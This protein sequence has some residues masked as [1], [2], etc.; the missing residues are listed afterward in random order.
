M[1]YQAVRYWKCAYDGVDTATSI[2]G[3][4]PE[5]WVAVTSGGVLNYFHN[6]A[7]AALGPNAP[8][9]PGLIETQYV[10][11]DDYSAVGVS[12]PTP[13]LPSGWTSIT[14]NAQTYYF[15]SQTNLNAWLGANP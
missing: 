2:D 5:N 11:T 13:D 8:H 1:G 10:F 12:R 14:R 9:A 7:H 3:A 4:L 15:S 6:T